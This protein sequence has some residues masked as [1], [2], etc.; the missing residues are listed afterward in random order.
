MRSTGEIPLGRNWNPETNGM[1]LER[2]QLVF[3]ESTTRI[4][5]RRAEAVE[6]NQ[7]KRQRRG[8]DVSVDEDAALYDDIA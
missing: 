3:P 5:K 2:P 8:S 4:M 6:E 7:A 1:C